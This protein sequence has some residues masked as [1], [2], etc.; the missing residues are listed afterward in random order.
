MRPGPIV[1]FER[2]ILVTFALGVLNVGLNWRQ[3][4]GSGGSFALEGFWF[5]QAIYFGTYAS[6]IWLI[7]RRGNTIA[8]WSFTFLVVAASLLLFLHLPT[9]PNWPATRTWLTVVQCPLSLFSL[10]LIFG[11]DTTSWFA[12]ARPVDPSVFD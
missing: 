5:G 1:W 8:R 11:S 4:M 3:M 6:L 9:P 7:S 10:I 2:L 12:G